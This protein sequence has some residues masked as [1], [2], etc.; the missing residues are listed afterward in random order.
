MPTALKMQLFIYFIIF[1]IGLAAGSFFNVVIYRFPR[2]ES[3]IFPRSSCVRCKKVLAASDLIPLFSYLLLKGRC[4]NCGERISIRYPSVELLTALLFIWCFYYFELTPFFFKYMFVFSALM[5]ISFI[6]LEH[7]IIPNRLVLLVFTWSVLWQL[8]IPTVTLQEAALGLLAGGGLFYL[9]AVLSKGG[10]GG[11]DIK[12]MAVLGF[13]VGWPLVLIV[14]LLAFLLGAVTGLLLVFAGKKTRRDP[15]PFGP[16]L[17]ISFFITYFWGLEI[18][19][20]Y[21]LYL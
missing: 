15:L 14:L 16:F 11:G 1:L 19:L 13:I 2:G 5:I 20:W 7:G 3:L 18:W 17:S 6:D 8:F 4:R 12:L 9:I 21:T 10:M